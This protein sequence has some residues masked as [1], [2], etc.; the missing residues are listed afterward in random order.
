MLYIKNQT[1]YMM[2]PVSLCSCN[3]LQHQT[4][5]HDE[6]RREK[7]NWQKSPWA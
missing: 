6:Q 4:I 7:L 2:L 3:Y 5:M 1:T